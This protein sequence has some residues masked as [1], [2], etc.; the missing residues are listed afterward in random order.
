MSD[1]GHKTKE[2]AVDMA[3]PVSK[4]AKTSHAKKNGLS[5]G[6]LLENLPDDMMLIVLQF[7]NMEDIQHTRDLQSKAVQHRTVC[8]DMEKAIRA[9]NLSNMKWIKERLDTGNIPWHKGIHIGKFLFFFL[10]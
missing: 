7:G 5:L 1:V 6:A 2:A 3:I 10:D 4:K 8:V 9:Y